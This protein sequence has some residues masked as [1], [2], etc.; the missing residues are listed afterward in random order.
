VHEYRSEADDVAGPG[1]TCRDRLRL[2]RRLRRA[3]SDR[4]VMFTMGSAAVNNPGAS[5]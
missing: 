3:V 2:A 5:R 1:T 4:P